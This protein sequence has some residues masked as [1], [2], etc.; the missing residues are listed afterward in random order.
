MVESF[1][2]QKRDPATKS[3]MRNHAP[4]VLGLLGIVSSA[5]FLLILRMGSF[6]AQLLRFEYLFFIIFAVY[7]L[8]VLLIL[9]VDSPRK[10]SFFIIIFFALVFRLILLLSVPDFSDDIMRYVWDGRVQAA[11]INPYLYAPT[12]P[13][14]SF[15][16]DSA[17]YPRI[18]YPNL[19]TIYPPIAQLFFALV[20]RLG[21]NSLVF[22]KTVIVILDMIAV[23][24]IA[25]L[26]NV[27]KISPL[28]SII[29]AWNPLVIL[30]FA[31]SGHIDVLAVLFLVAAVLALLRRRPGASGF[32]LA[33]ATLAKFYPAL[34][35][36]LF[37][38]KRDFKMPVSF[39]ST[40]ILG[41][42]PFI[43]AGTK[44]LGSLGTY[45]R[46][47]EF[48]GGLWHF[49]SMGL[50]YL[51][52]PIRKAILLR[53]LFI[54]VF[55]VASALV[56]LRKKKS[57]RGFLTGVYLV[58]GLYILLARCLFPWYVIWLIP[59]L[60]VQPSPGWLL[61]SGA[62]VL[63]YFAANPKPGPSY[64]V[65][66]YVEYIP[67]YFLLALEML[68]PKLKQFRSKRAGLLKFGRSQI[69]GMECDGYR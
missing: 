35:L 55:I 68:M 17:I 44:M 37:F 49:A 48:N 21:A 4:A 51:G 42:M 54:F 27:L 43:G 61:F 7:L 12:A 64:E 46:D 2:R 69:A 62:L 14:L 45:F 1:A 59:F 47:W 33:L 40:V 58:I 38:K 23:F 8:A 34:L 18:N 50:G 60:C 24:L 63:S 3:D 31:H 22:M 19:P 15:L 26:L 36:P 53:Y 28:R 20:Y 56:A 52:M 29:Y 65:L 9:G 16:R 39:V 66:R 32:F 11:G 25:R 30:E 13:Q 6:R 67:L 57:P 5:L 10:S 41:Y